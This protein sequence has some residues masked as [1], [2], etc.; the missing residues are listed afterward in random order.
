MAAERKE[1]A[2]HCLHVDSKVG[3]ALGTVDH[4]RHA[5]FV[6]YAYHLLDRIDRSEHVA[7]VRH[8]DNLS[9]FCEQFFVFIKPQ[10]ALVGHRNDTYR[11]AFLSRLELPGHDVG[12][13]FHY[14]DYH[15]VALLHHSVTERGHH[16]VK[17]LGG[18]AREYYLVR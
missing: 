3:S 17:A 1:I 9:P 2:V 5:V 10:L 8:A 4:Y 13:V 15:F 16:E 11:Y 14:R 12:V 6:G 18:S 7:H